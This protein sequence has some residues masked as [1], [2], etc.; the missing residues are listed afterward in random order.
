MLA[1]LPLSLD[2]HIRVCGLCENSKYR[3][4]DQSAENVIELAGAVRELLM[5][6]HELIT[7][8]PMGMP[9]REPRRPQVR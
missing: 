6:S 4:S 7:P 3:Y 1:G 9:S 8:E 5:R 2:Q